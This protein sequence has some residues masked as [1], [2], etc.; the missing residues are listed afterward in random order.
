QVL[1]ERLIDLD[2]VE[3][4]TVQIGETRIGGAE[5]VERDFHADLVELAQVGA[6]APRVLQQRRLGDL[7]L[8]PVR[9]KIGGRE[10]LA[11]QRRYVRAIELDRGQV[12]R[13][14]GFTRPAAAL[15][16]SLVERLVTDL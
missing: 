7:D 4:K 1:Q 11:H 12:D 16:T 8:E 5:I 13:D 15:E 2:L 14:R 10:R 3:R 6:G 9:R